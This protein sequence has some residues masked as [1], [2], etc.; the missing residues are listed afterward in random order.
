MY[1]HDDWFLEPKIVVI[2]ATILL[3]RLHYKV[4]TLP[5]GGKMS[6]DVLINMCHWYSHSDVSQYVCHKSQMIE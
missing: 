2:E 3:L 5:M 1:M 4:G 6:V